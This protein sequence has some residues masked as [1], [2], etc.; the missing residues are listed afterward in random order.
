[1]KLVL[2]PCHK[3]SYFRTAGWEE[4]WVETAQEM[5]RDVF[6]RSYKQEGA[7]EE[8]GP[9]LEMSNTVSKVNIPYSPKNEANLFG[10]AS[11][12]LK[13]MFD[14]LPSLCAPTQKEL[15][16]ELDRYL[17]TDPE[18]VDNVIL[19]WDEH[20]GMYPCLLRMA[21]DYLTIPGRSS[22]SFDTRL[23][24]HLSMFVS[25]TSV[26][27]E[28]IFSCGCLVLSHV[29]NQLSSQSTQALLCLGLWSLQDMVMDSDV[30][31]ITAL[32]E[33]EGDEDVELEDGWDRISIN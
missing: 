8:G 7:L 17:N 31:A 14:D 5:V 20:R 33:V 9:T 30:L 26:D 28:R 29:R 2:H 16:D 19:W 4:E 27:V 18:M 15:H 10:Q 25:A 24:T 1:M 21:L 12:K 3:L 22:F 32:E 23:S 11:S 6:E 13:N